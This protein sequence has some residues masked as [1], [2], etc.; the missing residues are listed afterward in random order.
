MKILTTGKG[1]SGSWKIRGVQLGG[2]NGLAIPN[3]QIEDCDIVVY[4]KRLTRENL[5]RIR[6]SR[7]PWVWDLVDFYPQPECSKWSKE[8]SIAWARKQI[9]AARPHGVIYPNQQ[10]KNDIGISGEVVYHHYYPGY[11]RVELREEIKIVGYDGNE[12]YLGCYRE[13]LERACEIRGW[14]FVVSSD[15]SSMDIIVAFRSGAYNG[16][17]QRAWKSNVKQANA[18]AAGVPFI[19]QTEQSYIETSNGNE[20]YIRNISEIE[21]AFDVVSD[22]SVRKDIRR[23]SSVITLESCAERVKQ[24]CSTLLSA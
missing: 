13:A 17:A 2:M 1:S 11:Q 15:I 24:Y 22:L 18:H 7:K 3:A 20:I 6:A 4:V 14:K 10:M 9:I 8:E 16:Y 23:L 12:K 21:K 5:K 19:C